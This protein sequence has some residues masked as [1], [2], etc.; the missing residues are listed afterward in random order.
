LRDKGRNHEGFD[1]GDASVGSD[2]E[3]VI[4]DMNNKLNKNLNNGQA[5]KSAFAQEALQAHNE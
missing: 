2:M 1:E 5:D 3:N 4:P